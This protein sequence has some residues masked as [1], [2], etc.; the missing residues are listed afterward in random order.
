MLFRSELWR[1]I[2]G[3][4]NARLHKK[5]VN[6]LASRR[7]P[8]NFRDLKNFLHRLHLNAPDGITERD[9]LELMEYYGP[10]VRA[11]R[12]RDPEDSAAA[13]HRLDCL[14][15]FRRTAEVLRALHSL[16][17]PVA[18]QQAVLPEEADW[19]LGHSF[20]ELE[21]LLARPLDFHSEETFNAVLAAKD[22]LDV[23]RTRLTDPADNAHD[24]CRNR[25]LPAIDNALSALFAETERME[26][27]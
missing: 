22:A 3:N 15:H 5:V 25:L 14:R 20:S 23:F 10:P 6:L 4:T 16:V 13:M 12:Q 7:W 27:P 18:R 9:V 8:G 1:G 2:T 26:R 24:H 21:F 19:T 17:Q 11:G